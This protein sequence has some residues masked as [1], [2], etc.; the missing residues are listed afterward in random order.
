M[1]NEKEMAALKQVA[2]LLDTM[3][4]EKNEA[5][6]YMAFG[7]KGRS[8]A[9]TLKGDPE[10]VAALIATTIQVFVEAADI[11]A[12]RNKLKAYFI[13]RIMDF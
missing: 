8:A 12:A 6:V 7:N 10:T 2:A 1:I 11:K 9:S 13:A 4:P 3:N 5:L